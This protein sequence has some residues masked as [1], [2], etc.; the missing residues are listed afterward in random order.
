MLYRARHFIL[1]LV[2]VK[3]K[4]THPDMTEKLLTGTYRIKSNKQKH[5]NVMSPIHRRSI[6][7]ISSIYVYVMRSVNLRYMNVMSAI[8]VNSS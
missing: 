8:S 1:C 4:K 7:V 3:P 6:Y 2:L 5:L